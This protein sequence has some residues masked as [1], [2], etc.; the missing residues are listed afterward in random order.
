LG[1]RSDGLR[2]IG[3]R[4]DLHNKSFVKNFAHFIAKYFS[5]ALGGEILRASEVAGTADMMKFN[6]C[7]FHRR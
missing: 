6:G 5:I 2:R 1:V 3:S 7:K 4:D